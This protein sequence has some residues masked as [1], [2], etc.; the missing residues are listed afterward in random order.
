MFIA[1]GAEDDSEDE[2]DGQDQDAEKPKVYSAKHV[3]QEKS[4]TSINKG[5]TLVPKSPPKSSP[6]DNNTAQEEPAQPHKKS[7]KAE[8][9]IKALKTAQDESNE[10]NAEEYYDEEY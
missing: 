10:E 2:A 3:I 7:A 5:T 6:P 1:Q 9:K 8:P 4:S